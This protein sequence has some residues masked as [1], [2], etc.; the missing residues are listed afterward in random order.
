MIWEIFEWPDWNSFTLA[1]ELW[2]SIWEYVHT[3]TI[4]A[5]NNIQDYNTIQ[6]YNTIQAYDDA[7]NSILSKTEAIL[8]KKSHL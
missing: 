5:Y 8:L 7:F 4:Q 3:D 1:L 2:L 6:V